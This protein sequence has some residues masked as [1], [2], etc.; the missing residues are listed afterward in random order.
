MK[1]SRRDTL[2][3]TKGSPAEVLLAWLDKPHGESR[4][5]AFHVK[6]GMLP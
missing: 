4:I 5:G 1:K 2:D 6:K 3:M